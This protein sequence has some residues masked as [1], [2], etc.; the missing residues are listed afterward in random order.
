MSNV[1]WCER[2]GSYE[3][4]TS[5]ATCPNCVT[6]P[7]V[8]TPQTAQTPWTCQICGAANILTLHDCHLALLLQIRDRL[9]PTT[10]ETTQVLGDWRWKLALEQYLASL[11]LEYS[12][13]HW[14][15]Q[16][17]EILRMTIKWLGEEM[18]KQGLSVQLT[19]EFS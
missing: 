18:K 9:S 2:H 1:Y 13:E 5:S 10:T 14:S 12:Y 17:K 6:D 4:T 3:P 16:E 15:S 11:R 19:P 8:V 7:P